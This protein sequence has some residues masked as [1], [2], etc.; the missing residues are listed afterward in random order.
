[1]KKH[2]TSK[3]NGQRKYIDAAAFI[4][5]WQGAKNAGEAAKKAGYKSA[6]AAS[7]R[8]SWLRAKGLK[9]KKMPMG[10]P[11]RKLDIKALSKLV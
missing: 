7:S 6:I 10:G 5:A 3:T 8:A 2:T 9:L 4:K 11:T 1:M